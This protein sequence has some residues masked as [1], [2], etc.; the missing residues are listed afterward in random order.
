MEL[1]TSPTGKGRLSGV[2]QR[3]GSRLAALPG[4]WRD[5]EASKRQASQSTF[6]HQQE[7][8]GADGGLLRSIFM[9]AEVQNGIGIL[10]SPPPAA[11]LG[12]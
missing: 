4:R 10:P 6:L 8:I 5:G 11:K 12:M 7:P 1:C 9:A 2:E 3:M